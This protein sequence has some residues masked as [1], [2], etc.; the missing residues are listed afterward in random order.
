MK[1]IGKL[2]AGLIVVAAV[3]LALAPR[4]EAHVNWSIGIG[5]APFGYA[6]PYPYGYPYAYPYGYPYPYYPYSYPS[7]APDYSCDYGYLKTRIS[8]ASADLYVDGGYVG[9]VSDIRYNVRLTPGRHH[10]EFRAPGYKTH[11]LNVEIQP[12]RTA[13]V[14]YNMYGVR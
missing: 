10:L 8:P 14:A 4:S 11:R 3:T 9:R 2:L 1:R 7:Y 6:S 12:C 13:V 5:V